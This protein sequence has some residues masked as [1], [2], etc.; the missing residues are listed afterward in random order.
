MAVRIAEGSGYTWLWPDGSV[1]HA[2]HYPVGYPAA[3]AL[4]YWALGA[5][6]G[7]AM[8]LNALVGA[9]G[10][11]AVHQML[12]PLRDRRIA[13][14]GG[15]LVAFHP[16]LVGY[17]PALMTEGVSASLVA[18]AAWA[19][20]AAR[21]NHDDRRRWLLVS[22]CGLLLGA[23]TLV[24][25][26]CLVLAPIFGAVAWGARRG[27][28][29]A[30]VAGAVV[31][32][33]ALAVCAPWTARNC[34]KMG[35]CALVSV[36]GGWNLLIGTDP[37]GEGAWAPLRTPVECREVF[38]EAAKDQCFQRAAGRTI[39]AAPGAWLALVPKKLSATFDYCGAAGWYLHDANRKAF[40]DRA[41]LVLG[42]AETVYERAVVILALLA[43]WPRRLARE[44]PGPIRWFLAAI[45]LAGIA[46][47]CSRHGWIAHLALLVTLCWRRPGL[48]RAHPIYGA[49]WAT[50]ACVAA[51]HA[52]FFGAGR[53]QMLVLPM[54]CAL[55]ALGLGRR[56]GLARTV[57]R[58]LGR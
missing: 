48:L 52:V 27:L 24:R 51:V 41:K 25:P 31:T 47:A 12:A 8:V 56:V 17:T 22:A 32:A 46:F 28:R 2:A 35:R 16:G 6:P 33:L 18:C 19:A 42:V 20:T 11:L 3:L 13:L 7:L 55:A 50:L 34:D 38:D 26:Q 14:V 5:V 10:C 39:V 1:T 53:Y 54:M 58:L 43:L 37:A 49:T 45:L 36:N 15:L 23:G 57:S 30:L 9:L 40:D 4:V 44:R 21:A 29:R